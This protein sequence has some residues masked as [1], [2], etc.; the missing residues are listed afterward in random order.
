MVALGTGFIWDRLAPE[1]W[2]TPVEYKGDAMQIFAWLKAA[3]E[4]DYL[5]FA[6]KTVSR[7]GAPY[8]ANWNDYPMYEEILTFFLGLCARWFGLAQA[9]NLGLLV[10]YV[11][12]AVVFYAC[13]RMLRFQR[14][15]SFVAAVLFGFTYY[16]SRRLLGH[17]LLTFSYVIPLA[18]V[19]CWVVLA[20]KRLRWRGGWFWFCLAVS[21]LLGLSNPYS[22]N[23][24]VQLLC[25]SIVLNFWRTRDL[26]RLKIG[27]MC[28]GAAVLGFLSVNLDTLGYAWVHGVN[29][30][31]T[32]RNYLQ[33]ELYALKPME[34][35]V[36]PLTHNAR[37]LAD[38]GE[39]YNSVAYVKGETFSP[40]LGVVA[41]ICLVWMALEF[42]WMLN[43]RKAQNRRV[44]AYSPQ[45][46]WILAYSIIG[47]V[48]NLLALAGLYLFRSANRYSTFVSTLVL[49]F[50]ASR[51][52]VVARHWKT[53]TRWAVALAIL[54]LGLYD[55][56]PRPVTRQT[57]L[58]I[59]KEFQKDAAFGEALEKALPK[60]AMV[61]QLPVMR[62]PEG[63]PVGEVQEYEMFRPYFFTKTLRFSFGSN[64]G[65]PRD[66]WQFEVEQ[67]PAPEMVAAL[68]KYGFSA[69]YLNR[70]GSADRAE[71]FLKGLAGLGKPVFI[72][73]ESHDQVCIRLNPSPN[74]ELPHSDENDLLNFKSG[75][76]A[77]ER[78][79]ERTQHWAGGNGTVSFFNEHRAP[80]PSKVT[81]YVGSMTARRVDIEFGGKK[82][83]G[84]NVPAA[85]A[86]PIDVWLDA[87]H[88]N[89][90]LKF[91]TDA[92]AAKPEGKSGPMVTF[93]VI[94]LK[95]TAASK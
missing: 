47:G 87:T 85:Q 10:T 34:F 55:E 25:L 18:I 66:D 37:V 17:L 30:A 76:V 60:G 93:S 21:F 24:F 4:M 69:I 79:P 46:I 57:T 39:K 65:R 6:S 54:A 73:D 14:L 51:M 12:S 27:L 81:G 49:F 78:I 86:V 84:V 20:S 3:S 31:A 5:P 7:L 26:V 95:V 52:S 40:Y 83:W 43:N 32:P 2:S 15:W 80:T 42:L 28:I 58:D 68:E 75:W 91:I 88:G 44:P 13:C 48:N 53:G 94:N 89:N 22:L 59:Q 62:F 71:A 90:T 36:P 61:F 19:V 67:K 70:R 50:F 77:E 23:M 82:I 63:G 56:L 29:P 38:I 8:A 72:E 9:T 11:P 92:P 45:C 16:N 74:P 64:Q 33:T 35:L 41:L 1:T